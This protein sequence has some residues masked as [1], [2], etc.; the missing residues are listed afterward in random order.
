MGD[1]AG[2]NLTLALLL[3][4]R[5]EGLP[6]PSGAVAISPWTDVSNSG[7]SMLANEATDWVTKRMAD[8]WASWYLAGR[9]PNDPFIS[10]L[11]ADLRGLPPIYIQAGGKEILIDQVKAFHEAAVQQGA[12]VKLD[13]WENMNHDFQAY[14]DMLEEAKQALERIASF[15]ACKEATIGNERSPD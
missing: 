5:A 9:K 2:G 12:Q 4:L 11:V 7:A 13:I 6:M 1:S 10:P 3:K 15:I 14:G 8:K